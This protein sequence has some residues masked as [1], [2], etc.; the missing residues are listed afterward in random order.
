MF[1]FLAREPD[2]LVGD[3]MQRWYII[4]RNRFFNIYLHKFV[5]D[6]EVRALHDHPWRSLSILLKGKYIEHRQG[7]EPKVFRRGSV[8]YRGAEYAHRIELFNDDIN[9]R[10]AVAKRKGKIVIFYKPLP[11]WTIFI[12]GRK[13]RDWGFHCPKGWRLWSDFVS[14]DDHGKVGRGCDD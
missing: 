13:I 12:T 11:V 6:D 7:H 1:K 4:P 8:I 2:F 3:Y 14:Q 10:D 9:W 5:G